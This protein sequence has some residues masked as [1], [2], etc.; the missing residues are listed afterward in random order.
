MSPES[1]GADYLRRLKRDEEDGLAT[2]A[3]PVNASSATPPLETERRRSPR[4]KC[5]GSAEFR[6]GARTYAPGERSPT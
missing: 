5:E 6:V 1:G 2:S 4:Y 3:E